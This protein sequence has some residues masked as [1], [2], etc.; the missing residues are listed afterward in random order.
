MELVLTANFR[1]E[2]LFEVSIKMFSAKK[3]SVCNQAEV[4]KKISISLN[5][6]NISAV[7]EIALK[8]GD[9]AFESVVFCHGTNRLRPSTCILKHNT[10]NQVQ[11]H[12][13]I[14]IKMSRWFGIMV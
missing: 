4:K 10:R 11:H 9:S 6:S 14:K 3:I 12:R 1:S 5:K 8:M 7:K 13:P 2:S